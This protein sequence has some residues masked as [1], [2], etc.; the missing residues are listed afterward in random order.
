MKLLYSI[1]RPVARRFPWLAQLYRDYRDGKSL[2]T[3][4]VVT[5]YGFKFSGNQA[6]EAGTFEPQEADII[7]QYLQKAEVFINVGANIG[8]YCCMALQQKVPT[9]AFEPIELN[10][11]YL[12]KNMYINSWEKD[13]EIF[14]LAIGNQI[15]LA[16]IYGG[17][18]AASLVKGWSKTPDYYRRW[19]PISTLD[20]IVGSRFEGRRCLILVDIEGAEL[21]LLQGAAKLLRLNPKP[22]WIVEI[23]ITEHMPQGV[24]VNPH[25]LSSFEIFWNN[26]YRAWT[27]DK[28]R[29]PVEKSEIETIARTGKNTLKTH[30][31]IFV[32]ETISGG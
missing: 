19:V 14:P 8:Y 10:L 26:G 32:A 25:L 2:S 31:F 9:L 7:R 17:G 20:R 18:T 16:E 29:Q 1:L 11:K 24:Q 30:N 15:G 21:S 23:C 3:V 4:P 28:H 12:Y 22:V 27:C 13:V 6:M 5:P